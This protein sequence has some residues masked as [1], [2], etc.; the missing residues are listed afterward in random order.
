M[1]TTTRTVLPTV[2]HSNLNV[3]SASLDVPANLLAFVIRMIST[4][5]TDPALTCALQIDQSFDSGATWANVAGFEARGGFGRG[6]LP[7]QP[8]LRVDLSR[9]Q[10]D[11]ALLR[12]RW[13]SQGTWV[14]GL[15]LDQET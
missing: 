8:Q 3:T 7:L 4:E 15:A 14:Y 2:S 6:G 13:T 10:R 1:A 5:F 11:A 9:E 12:A